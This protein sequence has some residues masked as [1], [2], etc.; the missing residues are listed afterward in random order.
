MYSWMYNKVLQAPEL[1]SKLVSVWG[2]AYAAP[3][4]S[5][6]EK[7]PENV[8]FKFNVTLFVNAAICTRHTED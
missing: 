2:T 3:L 4:C 6:G 8:K 5:D 7:S 1:S